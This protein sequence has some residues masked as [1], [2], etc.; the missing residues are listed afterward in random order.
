MQLAPR[1][2]RLRF[3]WFSKNR[4]AMQWHPAATSFAVNTPR[5]MYSSKKI[6]IGVGGHGAIGRQ[7]A[8]LGADHEFVAGQALVGQYLQRGADVAFAALKA[9]V[10]R[11][12]KHI[13]SRESGFNQRSRITRIGAV[14][15]LAE[16]RTDSE[17][18]DGQP[19]RLSKVSLSGDSL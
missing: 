14:R 5:W 1:F 16:I 8:A 12:V 4:V 18:R 13:E 19:L 11:R 3:N 10:D 15:R 2:F 9:I 17:R 7:V 6:A